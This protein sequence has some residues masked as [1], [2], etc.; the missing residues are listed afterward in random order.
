METLGLLARSSERCGT[1]R[2]DDEDG[3]QVAVEPSAAQLQ[4]TSSSN[5]IRDV[6]STFWGS[7]DSL[8]SRADTDEASRVSACETA[9]Q[10]SQLLSLAIHASLVIHCCFI[11]L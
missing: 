8:M 4:H 6:L 11:A 7:N 9:I 2:T 1:A 10:A 3:H 5:V